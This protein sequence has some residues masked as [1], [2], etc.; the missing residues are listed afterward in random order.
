MDHLDLSVGLAVDIR[1]VKGRPKQFDSVLDLGA[2]Y[3]DRKNNSRDEAYYLG[4]KYDP[5]Q[6]IYEKFCRWLNDSNR[7]HSFLVGENPCVEYGLLSSFAEAHQLPNPL[8]SIGLIT[9]EEL[10]IA[11]ERTKKR[12]IPRQH[13]DILT[14]EDIFLYVGVIGENGAGLTGGALTRANLEAETAVRLISGKPRRTGYRSN[15]G[16]EFNKFVKKPI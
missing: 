16:K 14:L 10:A 8:R 15:Y 9:I 7:T 2:I 12:I 6:S 5:P 13:E 1:L 4:G 3:L 11:Y